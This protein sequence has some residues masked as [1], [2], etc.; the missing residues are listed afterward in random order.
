L[1]DIPHIGVT[2]DGPKPAALI[3]RRIKDFILDQREIYWRWQWAKYGEREKLRRRSDLN[4][5]ANRRA[6]MRRYKA[7]RKEI[8]PQFKLLESL[9][10]KLSQVISRK[11]YSDIAPLLVV[12]YRKF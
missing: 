8:D 12:L 7:N 3:G 5:K 1:F 9:G 2:I 10:S 4:C 6:Y 11:L